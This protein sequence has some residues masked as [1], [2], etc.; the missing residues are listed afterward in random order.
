MGDWEQFHHTLSYTCTWLLRWKLN[1][2]GDL[3]RLWSYKS[4]EWCT[5]LFRGEI[6][7]FLGA[8]IIIEKVLLQRVN[9]KYSGCREKF[10]KIAG[11]NLIFSCCSG[12][13]Q[14]KLLKGWHLWFSCCRGKDLKF[15]NAGKKIQKK[16]QG[17]KFEI[18]L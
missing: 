5:F 10:K 1:L 14:K 16:L 18:L 12:K 7:N 6:W 2:L 9:L 8:G 11:W 17:V 13:I 3:L 15:S 4:M